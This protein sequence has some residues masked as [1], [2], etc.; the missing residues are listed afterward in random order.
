LKIVKFNPLLETF[1]KTPV[2]DPQAAPFGMTSDKFG[3]IWL[4]QHTVDKLGVYDPIRNEF[5]EV[6][7]PT[8]TSFTQFVNSDKDGNVWFV[9]QRGNK[10]GNVVISEVP[11]QRVVQEQPM[12][13][14]RYSELASPLMMVGIIATSLFFVKSIRDKRRIDLL[15]E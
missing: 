13:N 6:N 7:I 4:A 11:I 12:I 15:A 14:L 3:N 10:L 5:S 8:K 2:V 1:E 9:E